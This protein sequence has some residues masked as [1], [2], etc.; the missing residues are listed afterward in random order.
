[1][2]EK[3]LAVLEFPK[4][5]EQLVSRAAFAVSKELAAA[6]RPSADQRIVA[7]ALRET[8]EAVALLEAQPA[9]GVGGARDV[10]VV[11]DRAAHGARLEPAELLD[12]LMTLQSAQRVQATLRQL[13]ELAPLL[14]KRAAPI[15]PCIGVQEAI[16]RSIAEN[17]E[18]LDAASAALGRIRAAARTAHGR[19]QAAGNSLIAG[20]LR[21]LLQEPLVT[22]RAGRYVVPVKQEYRT[23]FRGIVHDQSASGATVFMEP[24]ELVDLNNRWRQAQIEEQQEIERIL[25]YLSGL[26]AERQD[27][28]VQAVMILAGVDLALAK[29]RYAAALSATCPQLATDYR[30]NLIE[31]RHPLLTGEVVPLSARLGGAAADGCRALIITGPNTGGKTVALK[32]MGLLS[33]M[34][35]AGLHIPTEAGSVV[36]VWDD[37][38]A[39]I[40]DEQSIEQSLSTF[41]SHMTNIVQIMRTATPRCLVLLDEI[42]VGTD[43]QEGSALARAVLSDLVARRVCTVATTHYSDLKAYAAAQSQI[44]NANVEFDANALRPTYRF[45]M[46]LPGRSYGLTI[47]A[48]LGLPEGVLNEARA[49]LDPEAMQV[50]DLL[51]SIQEERETAL[52]ARA[53]ATEAQQAA[54]E[55]RAE[56]KER[57]T[58]IEEERVQVLAAAQT[59]TE[60]VLAAAR[61]ALRRAERAAPATTPVARKRATVVERELAAVAAQAMELPARR[62]APAEPAAL[63]VGE[64]VRVR[65]LNTVGRILAPPTDRGEVEVQLGTLRTRLPVADLMPTGGDSQR[66]PA[67]APAARPAA[68]RVRLPAAPPVALEYDVRG[69]RVVAALAEIERYLDDAYRSDMSLVRIIH[70]RGTGV[71]REAIR[72]WLGE[73]PLVSDFAPADPANGG[74]GATVVHLAG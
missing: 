57:L 65:R 36:A 12:V 74:D 44:C 23:T 24:F 7:A 41:S 54:G 17:G 56:L 66:A 34:A 6:L 27:E 16:R 22:M 48:Q 25:L 68:A 50:D 42:G 46:G 55:L 9:F 51:A 45:H 73:H 15:E 49:L 18:V 71:L 31:A 58:R 21:T 14:A 11:V 4:I 19:L 8:S 10:R 29:A 70:G 60:G 32:T 35:Q 33:L 3:S 72:D 64:R 67:P 2:N 26:V 13:R 47:A 39:D 38:F 63:A 52:A 61:R 53:A 59:E 62:V 1:M 28:I 40:G 43:P 20:P 37:I 5:R 69:R 30:L